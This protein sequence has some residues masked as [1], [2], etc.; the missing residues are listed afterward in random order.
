MSAKGNADLTTEIL[1]AITNVTGTEGIDPA[2]LGAVLKDIIDSFYDNV[3]IILTPPP[4]TMTVAALAT[5]IGVSGLTDKQWILVTA[6]TDGNNLWV[7]AMGT[8]LISP[9][10][11]WLIGGTAVPVIMDYTNGYDGQTKAFIWSFRQTSTNAAQLSSILRNS[12]SLTFGATTAGTNTDNTIGLNGAVEGDCVYL[13][14]DSA[15]IPAAA[16]G[17]IAW[18][19]SPNTVT[20]RFFNA[21]GT[22]QT[23][24]TGTFTV[25]IIK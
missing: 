12:A 17:Y 11:V 22:T 13:G 18:V 1:N 19:S 23:P 24:G 21:S 2:A 7:Q 15:A 6:R 25:T 4:T 5:A 9:Y 14:I 10:G 3:D 8:N 20:V 16:C